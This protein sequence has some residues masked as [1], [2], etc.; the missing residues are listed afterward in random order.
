[1]MQVE[2]AKKKRQL[3]CAIINETSQ[4]VDILPCKEQTMMA[5][6]FTVKLC[7]NERSKRSD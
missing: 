3:Q 1:M 6:Y 4:I 2:T 5:F 7:G